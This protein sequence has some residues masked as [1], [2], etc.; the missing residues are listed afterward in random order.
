MQTFSL[1]TIS[2][3]QLFCYGTAWQ[4]NYPGTR[5]DL[6]KLA[7]DD[8]VRDIDTTGLQ[9]SLHLTNIWLQDLDVMTSLHLS[10]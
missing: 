7:L 10:P 4:R 6:D 5:P 8:V 2:D 9:I 1:D 3:I